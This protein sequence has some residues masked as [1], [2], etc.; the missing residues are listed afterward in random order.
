[1]NQTVSPG[2]PLAVVADTSNLYVGVNVEETDIMKI[3]LGQLVDVR[4]DA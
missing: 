2:T 4:L 1:M 3:H